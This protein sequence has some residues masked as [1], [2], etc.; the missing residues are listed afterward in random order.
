MTTQ[1][2]FKID[3]ELKKKAQKKAAAEGISLSIVLKS[4]MESYTEDGFKVGLIPKG[5]EP[6]KMTKSEV[7]KAQK[8]TEEF[9]KGNYYTTDQIRHELGL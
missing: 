4:A 5:W 1:V 6:V 7:K 3:K 9:K 8:A 2:I